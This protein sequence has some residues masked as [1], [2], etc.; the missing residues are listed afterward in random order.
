MIDLT[1]GEYQQLLRAAMRS[2]INYME[3]ILKT[4]PLIE[5]FACGIVLVNSENI[6]CFGGGQTTSVPIIFNGILISMANAEGANIIEQ[7]G[8]AD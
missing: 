6:R 2:A 8:S 7:R 4:E 5:T 3:E 1:S